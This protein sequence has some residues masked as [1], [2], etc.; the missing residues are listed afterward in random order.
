[1]TKGKRIRQK[2][3]IGL[4]RYFRKVKENEM[5]A[6]VKEQSV[7]ASF[8]KRIGG[9]SGRVVGARGNHYLVEVKDGNKIKTFIIHPIHLKKLK[10]VTKK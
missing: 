4:S 8:P 5:V 10:T 9:K 2:G 7:R 3:K 1:M 6:I